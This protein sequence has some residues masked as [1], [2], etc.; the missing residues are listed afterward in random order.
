MSRD[1]GLPEAVRFSSPGLAKA[2]RLQQTQAQDAA[3]WRALLKLI[4]PG[5]KLHVVDWTQA[6]LQLT[7]EALLALL[8]AEIAKDGLPVE[9]SDG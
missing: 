1:S 5:R 7:P 6:G 4:Q 9:T 2:R 3:R 8:D